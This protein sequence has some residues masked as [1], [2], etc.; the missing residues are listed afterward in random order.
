MGLK[1]GMRVRDL[2]SGI[3]IVY[4]KEEKKKK[5]RKTPSVDASSLLFDHSSPNEHTPH[6]PGHGPYQP[7]RSEAP[8]K[9]R[10][11]ERL[12]TDLDLASFYTIIL[13]R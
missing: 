7:T 13:M 8:N 11:G 9:N 10:Q 4:S 6:T 3:Y 12:R 5:K 1:L 2:I